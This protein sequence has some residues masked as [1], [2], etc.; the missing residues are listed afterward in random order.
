MSADNWTE[1]PRC[2]DEWEKRRANRDAEL[3]AAYGHVPADEYR[4][5]ADATDKANSA[6]MPDELREDYEIG[7]R[8]GEFSVDYRAHCETCGY[9]FTYTHSQAAK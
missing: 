7:V 8:A 2:A 3:L 1:C 6:Q 4:K 5:R 9:K